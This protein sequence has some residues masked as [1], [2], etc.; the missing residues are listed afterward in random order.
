MKKIILSTAAALALVACSASA[1]LAPRLVR[2]NVALCDGTSASGFKLI[3]SEVTSFA[4]AKYEGECFASDDVHIVPAD[5]DVFNLD[6]VTEYLTA[7]GY[8]DFTPVLRD[9]GGD[10]RLSDEDLNGDGELNDYTT[11][12]DRAH[13]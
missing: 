4:A 10:K 12:S 9:R 7:E 5:V 13:W 11:T 2:S 1:D 3:G 6:A 8:A